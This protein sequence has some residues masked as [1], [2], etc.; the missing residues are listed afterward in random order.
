[1]TLPSFFAWATIFFHAAFDAGFPV[2]AADAALAGVVRFAEAVLPSA[3]SS[4]TT[5]I[6]RTSSR[7]WLRVAFLPTEIS[8][9]RWLRVSPA[10]MLLN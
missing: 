7:D 9:P 4:T 10:T 8:F 6:D 3:A 1:V 5:R 2:A